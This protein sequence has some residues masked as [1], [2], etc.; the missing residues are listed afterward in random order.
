M[1]GFDEQFDRTV[2][3]SVCSFALAVNVQNATTGW[4]EKRARQQNAVFR[5]E[6]QLSDFE[7]TSFDK[8]KALRCPS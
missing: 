4:L 7:A 3:S 2:S 6:D 8:S 1:T 5:F